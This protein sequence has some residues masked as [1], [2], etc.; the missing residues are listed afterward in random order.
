MMHPTIFVERGFWMAHK[1]DT[2][3]TKKNDNI[4]EMINEAS[5]ELG[6]DLNTKSIEE[7]PKSLA[8]RIKQA[9]RKR[10]R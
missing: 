6:V 2:D 9:I 8:R 7:D 1:R 5:E 3:R 10:T 4:E